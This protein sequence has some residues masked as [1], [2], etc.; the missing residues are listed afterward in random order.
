MT[1]LALVLT[2]PI[3]LSDRTSSSVKKLFMGGSQ[4]EK[5]IVAWKMDVRCNIDSVQGCQNDL[6]FFGTGHYFVSDARTATL[7]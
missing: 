3:A 5:F 2:A 4:F 7:Y 6:A 1:K